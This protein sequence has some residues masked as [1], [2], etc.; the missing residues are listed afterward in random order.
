MFLPDRSGPISALSLDWNTLSVDRFR[1]RLPPPGHPFDSSVFVLRS[2]K[3]SAGCGYCA[4]KRILA[5]FDS[6]A[7]IHPA[8]AAEWHPS[9]NGD[10][11]PDQVG[12]GSGDEVAAWLCAALG[13][14]SWQPIRQ[15]VKCAGYTVCS[16]RSVDPQVNSLAARRPDF[17]KDWHVE[18][19]APLRPD[20]VLETT[21]RSIWWMCDVEG[22]DPMR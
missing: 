22:H 1:L 19:N 16:N 13:H 8:D 11:K 5:G 2:S 12:A 4:G 6:L 15:R 14:T 17:A 10:L 3:A 20:E 9:L 21:E 7:D 18:L